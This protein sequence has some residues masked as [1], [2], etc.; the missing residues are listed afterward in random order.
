MMGLGGEQFWKVSKHYLHIEAY[1]HNHVDN[2]S[3]W[4]ERPVH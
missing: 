1:L 4:A 2:T 3:P